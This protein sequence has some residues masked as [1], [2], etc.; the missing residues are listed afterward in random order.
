MRWIDE[1]RNA[2]PLELTQVDVVVR[3]GLRS[4]DMRIDATPPADWGDRFS[5]MARCRQRLFANAGDWRRWTGTFYADLPRGDVAQLKHYVDTP[6]ALDSGQ[7][8]VRLWLDFQ[9][10]Q[11]RSATADVQ[12]RE[13]SVRLGDGI[14]PLAIAQ[15]GGRL[16]AQRDPTGVALAAEH[17]GFE[18]A[19]GIVWPKGDHAFL[20]APDAGQRRRRAPVEPW[21][22]PTPGCAAPAGERGSGLIRRRTAAVDRRRRQRAN[23]AR[24]ACADRDAPITGWRGLAADRLDL[25]LMRR[26]S[27]T[28]PLPPAAR[29]HWL[30]DSPARK[31]SS[32]RPCSPA[33]QAR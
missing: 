14:E 11:W 31:A 18:T 21:L 20:V 16:S 1:Q 25:S 13:V 4:H 29:R 26:L 27:A 33:D 8:A 10:D 32:G 15:A 2:P 7:G 5:L 12:L 24:P 17:F 19:S 6:F 30:A 3:N 22:P 9:N 23:H 28:L